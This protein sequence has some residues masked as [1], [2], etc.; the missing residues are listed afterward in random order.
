M[1]R[2][3]PPSVGH[4]PTTTV[5]SKDLSSEVV[6]QITGFFDRRG[7]SENIPH[8]Y[9]IKDSHSDFIRG[10]FVKID[11]VQRGRISCLLSVKPAVTVNYYSFP[12]LLLL[13]SSSESYLIAYLT[14]TWRLRVQVH[15]FLEGKLTKTHVKIVFPITVEE[16]WQP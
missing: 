9:T 13:S 2:E 3:K 7:I 12:L 11:L 14:T 15:L 6:S 4:S 1:E 5:I 16:V 8:N 10:L